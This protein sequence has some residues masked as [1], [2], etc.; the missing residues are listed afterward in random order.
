MHGLGP[1]WWGGGWWKRVG[2]KEMHLLRSSPNQCL[3]GLGRLLSEGASA[4]NG[5]WAH[6]KQQGLLDLSPGGAKI[7][8]GGAR[9]PTSPTRAGGREGGRARR[10]PPPP[11]PA[12]AGGPRCG[13]PGCRRRRWVGCG[14]GR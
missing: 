7:K 13:R 1:G 3:A 4:V 11:P 5:T 2:L 9:P 10:P 6:L 14:A 12:A 8:W